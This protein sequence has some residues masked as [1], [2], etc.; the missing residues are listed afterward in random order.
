[1]KLTVVECRVDCKRTTII[2]GE[3]FKH[4]DTNG[5][6]VCPI[7]K[8]KN[9]NILV[10]PFEIEP[11]KIK[12][13]GGNLSEKLKIAAALAK[14]AGQGKAITRVEQ[15]HSTGRGD[16]EPG[17]GTPQELEEPIVDDGVVTGPGS[18]CS[19]YE[20]EVSQYLGVSPKFDI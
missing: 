17:E 16:D 6:F 13:K 10:G 4:G 20:A 3:D 11:P 8:G 15:L 12:I 7:C 2:A 5:V 19:E 18:S 14:F 9:V 1:M